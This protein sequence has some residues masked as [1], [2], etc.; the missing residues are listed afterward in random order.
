MSR[1]PITIMGGGNRIRG[2]HRVASG[3]KIR[4]IVAL[5]ARRRA[6]PDRVLET[7]RHQNFFV[8]RSSGKKIFGFLFSDYVYKR[9]G[10]VAF[11][12]IAGAAAFFMTL[13]TA[14]FG[15]HR[16]VADAAGLFLMAAAVA[17]GASEASGVVKTMVDIDVVGADPVEEIAVTFNTV[18]KIHTAAGRL[19]GLLG[20]FLFKPSGHGVD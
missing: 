6:I 17:I 16:H 10:R 2:F 8:Y 12:T 3:T 14:K 1:Y 4:I 11:L 19:R 18:R 20:R 15:N 13:Q 5:P 7:D 9:T